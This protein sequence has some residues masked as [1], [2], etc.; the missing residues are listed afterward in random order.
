VAVLA[1]VLVVVLA[2]VLAAVLAAA[3]L[4]LYLVSYTRCDLSSTLMSSLPLGLTKM[5]SAA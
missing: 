4:E 3:V 5:A 2:S 1:A